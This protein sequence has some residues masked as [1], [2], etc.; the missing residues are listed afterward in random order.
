MRTEVCRMAPD[1]LIC[2]LESA[3][4]RLDY[5]VIR[6]YLQSHDLLED[7]KIIHQK[8]SGDDETLYPEN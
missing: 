2:S 8:K 5:K 1:P 7:C 6:E 3:M 4:F